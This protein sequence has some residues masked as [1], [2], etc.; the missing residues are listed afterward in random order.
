LLA[1]ALTAADPVPLEQAIAAEKSPNGKHVM[2][3]THILVESPN[4]KNAMKVKFIDA[5]RRPSVHIKKWDKTVNQIKPGTTILV[6][7][8]LHY[9]KVSGGTPSIRY[10][11]KEVGGR[12]YNDHR[13]WRT[14]QAIYIINP[15]YEIS[16]PAAAD[17][18]KQTGKEPVK[19]K[20][21]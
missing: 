7:G 1:L 15:K 14:D 12:T 10:K 6:T 20:G 2:V 11:V 5:P 3:Q 8:E 17:P 21:Q 13:H 9:G 18:A 4:D 16:K 19:E